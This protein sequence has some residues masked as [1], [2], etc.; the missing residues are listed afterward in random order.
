MDLFPIAVVFKSSS[1][2]FILEPGRELRITSSYASYLFVQSVVC[3]SVFNL[4]VIT[5]SVQTLFDEDFLL[6]SLSTQLKDDLLV[7][8]V[9]IIHLFA[10]PS[11][12]RTHAFQIDAAVCES[13]VTAEREWYPE[14]RH[15]TYT[16][17]SQK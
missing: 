10:V 13:Y 12:A 8:C 14:E 1:G 5:F 4:V 11:S 17:G 9:I 15:G 6:R 2:V 7:D 3:R 16:E